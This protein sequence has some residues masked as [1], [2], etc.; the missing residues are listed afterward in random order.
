M[1]FTKKLLQLEVE[2]RKSLIAFCQSRYL[3]QGI[4]H[5]MQE[6]FRQELHD[7]QLVSPLG[8][9]QKPQKHHVLLEFP[10][11]SFKHY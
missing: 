9:S 6:T 4:R 7:S 11:P 5:G 2:Y 8:P 3:T 1:V 10:T